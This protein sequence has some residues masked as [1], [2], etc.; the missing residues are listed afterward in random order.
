MDGHSSHISL[1][2]SRFCKEQ[3]IELVALYPNATHILQPMDVAVFHSLKSTWRQKVQELRM[4]NDGN[5]LKKQ[6]F[7]V[8]YDLNNV[9]Y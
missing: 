7:A 1:P 2:L 3:G 9:F 4:E 5:Q 8:L 6:D